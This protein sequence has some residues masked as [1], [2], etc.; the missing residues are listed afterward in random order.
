M[1][2]GADIRIKDSFVEFDHVTGN[3][4]LRPPM[5]KSHAEVRIGA[6]EKLIQ[7]LQCELNAIECS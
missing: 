1:T 6:I 2:E 3:S 4:E 5:N 7:K